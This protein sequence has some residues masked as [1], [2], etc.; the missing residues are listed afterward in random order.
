MKSVWVTIQNPT[1]VLKLHIVSCRRAYWKWPLP[2]LHIE[3]MMRLN[4]NQVREPIQQKGY[5]TGHA[6][7]PIGGKHCPVRREPDGQR[8]P[9]LVETGAQTTHLLT[10]ILFVL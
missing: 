2:V 5:S 1:A 8:R 4:L 10:R 9:R 3:R 7:S 6:P